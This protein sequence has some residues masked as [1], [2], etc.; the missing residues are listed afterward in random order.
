MRPEHLTYTVNG[1][2]VTC[3]LLYYIE[4]PNEYHQ[5]FGFIVGKTLGVA[6]CHPDDTFSEETG[7]K[8]ALAKAEAKAYLQAKR[9]MEKRWANVVNTLNGLEDMFSDFTEKAVRAAEHNKEYIERIT[10]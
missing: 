8:I 2:E 6:K 10:Q 5:I 9:E 7:R 1:N 3:E 4:A